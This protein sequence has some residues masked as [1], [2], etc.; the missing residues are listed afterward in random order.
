[1]PFSST[2]EKAVAFIP[3]LIAWGSDYFKFMVDDGS[4][5]GHPGLPMLGQA[6]LDAGV[7]EAERHGMLTVVHTLTVETTRMAIEAGID[8]LVHLF[9]D[10]P[11]PRDPA[12][13]SCPAWP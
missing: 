9:L 3:Q 1:M 11:H 5:G 4:I 2:P 10:Q 12:C 13:S 6:T 7:A 8:G